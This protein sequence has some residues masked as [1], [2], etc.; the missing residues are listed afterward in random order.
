LIRDAI[1]DA[2]HRDVTIDVDNI[3]VVCD[4]AEVW[5]SGTVDSF[6]AFRC[7][8]VAA[9]DTPGVCAVHN[10]IRILVPPPW[11]GREEHP[12]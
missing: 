5:L 7:A 11:T 2:L 8:E 10:H 3:C 12:D 6:A 4:G 1:A 9:R